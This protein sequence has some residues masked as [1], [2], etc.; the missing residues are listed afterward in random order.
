MKQLSA[1]FILG[2]LVLS[3]CPAQTQTGNASYNPSKTGLTISHSSLSFNTRVRVTNLLNNRS[4]EAVVNGRIAISSERIA[5]I[6]GEAGDALGMNKT[7]MTLVEIAELPSRAGT[8][9]NVVIPAPAPAPAAVPA[10]SSQTPQGQAPA[11]SPSAVTQVLPIQTIT[12]VQYVPVPGPV[13]QNCCSPLL[14]VI[15]ALLVLIIILLVVILILIQRRL[16]LWPWHYPVWYRR[17]FLYAKKYR[18]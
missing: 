15:F 6:S 4:V 14:W 3:F 1:V 8:V 9:Q 17:H 16:L 12:D 11:T 10:A 7:G 5:D 18:R 2:F 13:Q